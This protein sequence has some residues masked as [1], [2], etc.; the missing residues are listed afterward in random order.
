MKSIL[1]SIAAVWPPLVLALLSTS[2][3]SIVPAP[4]SFVAVAATMFF[5]F[6]AGARLLEYQRARDLL[7]KTKHHNTD[8][9][10][11]FHRLATY[12]KASYCR[13]TALTWAAIDALGQNGRHIISI[14]YA[15]LGYKWYHFTPDHTFTRRSP[16][17]KLS[18]WK[19][20]LGFG[21]RVSA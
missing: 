20:S 14:Y 5:S 10:T 8:L 18:F 13:R 21:R 7:N 19:D 15:A 6:D 16:F 2:V 12:H 17:L 4:G 1:H 3:A 9:A 11:A